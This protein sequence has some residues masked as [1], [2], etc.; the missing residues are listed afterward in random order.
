MR[1]SPQ[2]FF[3][4]RPNARELTFD[5]LL[6]KCY[7]AD[8]IMAK[9]RNKYYGNIANYGGNC[10][11]NRKKALVLVLSGTMALSVSGVATMA[12]GISGFK[13]G[14]DEMVTELSAR[15]RDNTQER[16][17]KMSSL[18][19]AAVQVARTEEEARKAAEEAAEEA[20]AKQEAEAKARKEKEEAAER[21]RQ[22]AEKA[23]KEAAGITDDTAASGETD[24]TEASVS[25]ET[26]V[27]AADYS[28]GGSTWYDPGYDMLYAESI[29]YDYTY[30]ADAV[31]E[32]VTYTEPLY[33][34]DTA[35]VNN[36]TEPSYVEPVYEE[37]VYE[38]PVYEEPV[39]EQPV[40]EEPVYEEPI[41]EETAA[42]DES[43]YTDSGYGYDTYAGEDVYSDVYAEETA[44]DTGEVRA[45][46]SDSDLDLLASIIYCEAGGES[47]EGQVAVGAVVLNRMDSSLYPD[48]MTDVI[49]QSGQFT[50]AMT[51][52][53]DQVRESGVPDYCYDAAQA[54]L[55]G[56]NPVGD[57]LYFH[58]GG[59]D[60][61]T[62]GNQTFY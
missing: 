48:D 42:Y 17:R 3:F 57:C 39:Y 60:G 18:V 11:M 30:A 51:G 2:P 1:R 13:T 52:W 9:N 7:N 58:A 53:L 34:Y 19:K 62:I 8:T 16:V 4:T 31:Y 26:T 10:D 50:P 55:N 32:D 45:V 59:G 56:E 44:E 12:D 6:I 46:A 27:Y 21:A 25:P 24:Y 61:L 41:Y 23:R 33:S 29:P 47:Y 49:Y 37:P 14:K 5:K 15:V 40:Y 35:A 54:A 28:A 22:E 36:Y 43:L 38:Q 20:K